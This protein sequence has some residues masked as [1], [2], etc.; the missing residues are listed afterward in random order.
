VQCLE[1][2]GRGPL[3][4]PPP[5][6]RCRAAAELLGWQ[7]PPRGGGAGHVDDRGEAVAVGDGP[8]PAAPAGR[9][10]GGSN[11]STIAQSSSGTSWSMRVVMARDHAVPHPKGANDVSG[12]RSDAARLQGKWRQVAC[13]LACSVCW[14]SSGV[15]EATGHRSLDVGTGGRRSSPGVGVGAR[16]RVMQRTAGG[17]RHGGELK[18]VRH[19]HQRGGPEPNLACQPREAGESI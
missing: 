10:G 18:T 4:Q 17:H 19:G 6:R 9:G 3:V 16:E 13:G 1:H 15:P 2:P 12:P 5:D 14:P 11:G 7:Q 8:R